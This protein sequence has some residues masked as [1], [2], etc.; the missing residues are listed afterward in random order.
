MPYGTKYPSIDASSE[1]E[2]DQWFSTIGGLG[3]P[4]L[5]VLGPRPGGTLGYWQYDREREAAADVAALVPRQWSPPPDVAE[6]NTS[7]TIRRIHNEVLRT[8]VQAVPYVQSRCSSTR[9]RSVG[10][11]ISVYMGAEPRNTVLR[12]ESSR[13]CLFEF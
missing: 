10:S 8:E 11:V 4:K 13:G 1:L 3:R 12:V 7:M 5:R 6:S 2:Y 9:W